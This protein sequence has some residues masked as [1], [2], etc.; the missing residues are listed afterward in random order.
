MS[1]H[2]FLENLLTNDTSRTGRI[3]LALGNVYESQG[4]LDKSFD[5]HKRSLVQFKE[6]VGH[7]NHRTVDVCH[8][9][10]GHYMRMGKW[11]SAK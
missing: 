6:T 11:D 10:A 7:S 8:K 9:M 3:L 4:D 1:H 5:F 2:S